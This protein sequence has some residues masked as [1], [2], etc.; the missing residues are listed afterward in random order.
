MSNYEEKK[1]AR[2]DRYRDL[3]DKAD[4]KSEAAGKQASSLLSVIPPGQPILIGHH[5]EGRHRSHLRRVDSKMGQCVAESKKADHYRSKANAAES[6]RAISSDDPEALKLLRFKLADMER[7]RET[8]K[9][10]NAAWRKAKRPNSDDLEGWEKVR[11]I[12]KL[13]KHMTATLRVGV[14]NGPK[15]WQP[16]ERYQL[17][18]LGGNIKNVKDR[19]KRLEAEATAEHKETEHDGFTVVE[20]VDENRVQI[21]FPGKPNAETRTLLKCNGFRWAPSQGAWQRQ[22]NNAGRWAAD[23]VA[24]SIAQS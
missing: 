15:A 13:S 18:N 23:T 5:S 4:A 6:N 22:L 19:I 10:I 21:I 20:N 3:A 16:F 7:R 2:I 1:Q 14:G 9:T 8:M 24:K 11:E 12:A 17:S